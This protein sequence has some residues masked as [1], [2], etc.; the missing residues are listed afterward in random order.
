MEKRVLE[1]LSIQL[2][3]KENMPK[4]P[5][6]NKSFKN[7][8]GLSG[9]IRL[10]H[11]DA[12]SSGDDAGH[13]GEGT[14]QQAGAQGA[15]SGALANRSGPLALKGVPLLESLAKEMRLP[16]EMANGSKEAF[17]SGVEYGMKTIMIG[18][19]AAQELSSMA[20]SQATP[21]INMSKELMAANQS[22]TRAEQAV[23]A[24]GQ[25][26]EGRLDSMEGRRPDVSQ[27]ARPME[28]ALARTLET[29]INRFMSKF[30]GEGDEKTERYVPP[31]WSI[32]EETE[33]K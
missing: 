1:K 6:C 7:P 9:H 29:F 30:N 31:S 26:L 25:Y 2:P 16:E 28:A 15:G 19:R 13:E 21:L 18:I 5:H 17:G 8:Q 32:R 14:N 20:I 24:L 4:C 3:G 27:S 22:S 12:P 23:H 33:S 11:P 10:N